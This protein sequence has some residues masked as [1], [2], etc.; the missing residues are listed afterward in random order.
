MNIL[1]LDEII[2]L[3][4][5]TPNFPRISA[6]KPLFDCDA[7]PTNVLTGTVTN[8]FTTEF[9]E[10]RY[11]TDYYC[12]KTDRSNSC[13]PKITGEKII[14]SF[15]NLL[16]CDVNDISSLEF[17]VLEALKR[18]AF[19]SNTALGLSLLTWDKFNDNEN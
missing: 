4:R 19:I 5:K 13:T 12:N 11:E 16:S 2:D 9:F 15:F 18:E 17:T 7:H 8:V 6:P 3:L 14:I 10:V 1:T